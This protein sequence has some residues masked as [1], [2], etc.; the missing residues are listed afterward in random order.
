MAIEIYSN[1]AAT[2]LA[3]GISNSAVSLTVLSGTG[4][5]F[6]NPTAGQFFRFTLNDTLTGNVFEIIYATART[7][8]TFSGLSRGQ[9]GTTAVSWLSGDKVFAGPTAGAMANLTQEQQVQQN[10]FAFGTDGGSANAYIITMAPTSLST[11]VIGAMVYF[12]AGNVNTGASTI[13]VAGGSTYPLL[14]AARVALQGGEVNKLCCVTFDATLAS[15]VLV[16]STGGKQQVVAGSASGQAINLGQAD[17]RYAALN[18]SNVQ[19][20]Y[21]SQFNT[22]V[23]AANS[24]TQALFLESNQYIAAVNVG[25]S[26][27]MPLY[28]ANPGGPFPAQAAVNQG[29]ADARYAFKAG[30]GGQ[31]F[32]ANVLT[33]N[34]L[35]A[36]SGQPVYLSGD[37]YTA[38]VNRPINNYIPHYCANPNTGQAAVNLQYAQGN[39]AA[40]GGNFGIN[41]AVASLLLNGGIYEESG[42]QLV[43]FTN[44][45]L[46]VVNLAGNA[47]VPITAGPSTN[48]QQVLIQN[49]VQNPQVATNVQFFNN[50]TV[51]LSVSFTVPKAGILIA[52]EHTNYS[53]VAGS[54][55]STLYINGTQLASD[56]T[57]QSRNH[58]VALTVGSAGGAS[59]TVIAACGVACSVWVALIYLPFVG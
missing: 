54:N 49:Q 45:G 41:F 25:N 56:T 37:T 48:A 29:F 8:D 18:G 30:S 4:N 46:A 16:W 35:Q 2:T 34:V 44:G 6:P 1:N 39:F 20:F 24:G 50:T 13:R 12:V 32:S 36:S 7:G 3:A 11:P 15:Y 52:H 42:G 40:I 17:A 38:S 23:V 53:S 22:T 33:A 10:T 19:P 28:V 9:E 55:S 14:G 26:A 21:A 31:N 57:T 5:E 51:T 43:M 47:Y 58:T 27:Y 59:A